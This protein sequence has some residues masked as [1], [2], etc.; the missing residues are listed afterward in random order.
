MSK[1]AFFVK[2]GAIQQ[3]MGKA[4]NPRSIGPA[5]VRRQCCVELDRSPNEGMGMNGKQVRAWALAAVA[6]ILGTSSHALADDPP[7][8]PLPEYARLILEGK[9]LPTDSGISQTGC[10][11]NLGPAPM[12]TGGM[13]GG[14]GDCP[15]GCP[16]GH[17]V[18]GRKCPTRY[19]GCKS[20]GGC[21]DDCGRFD[22]LCNGLFSCFC[23]PD[24]CYEPMWLPVANSAF[25]VDHA[26][27]QSQMRIRYD[28]GM[29]MIMPDRNE[30]FWARIGRKGPR[31]REETLNYHDTSLYIETG[32]GAFSAIIEGP[33]YRV[34][35]TDNN[36]FDAGWGDM[37]VGT[38]S[39]FV[40]CEL[41]QLTFQFKT[42]IPIGSSSKGF[43][44]GHVSLEPSLLG[45]IKMTPKTYFEFQLSEWI[46]IAGDNDWAGDVFHYHMS[47]NHLWCQKKAL[48]LTTSWEYFGYAFQDGAYTN[49]ASFGLPADGKSSREAYH[50]MGPGI[51]LTICDNYDIGFGAAFSLTDDHFADQ[52]YRFEARMRY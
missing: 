29:N 24:P 39:M 11:G 17:C 43:G 32:S 14:A 2:D 38:K 5:D 30:W 51:R 49:P 3:P 7:A 33:F 47:F 15:P 52:L 18:P 10:C 34:L 37:V 35:E 40:D 16:T 48:Q 19:P 9:P 8:G 20:C 23:C 4:G 13:G 44:T 6:T 36:G 28:L 1:D 42:W 22:K 45:A 26:R 12:I 25:F 41:M 50:Y 31:N 27:P 21:D 46:P